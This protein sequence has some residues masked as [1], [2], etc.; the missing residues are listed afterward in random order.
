MIGWIIGDKEQHADLLITEHLL[1]KTTQHPAFIQ[2]IS[3]A[4]CYLMVFPL[5]VDSMPSIVKSFMELMSENSQNFQGKPIYFI[6]HSGFPE[7]VQNELLKKYT[8]YFSSNIMKMNYKGTL[9]MAGSEAMQMA[10]D[11]YFNKKVTLF[12][13]LL[14]SIVKGANFDEAL[15]MKLS[16]CYQ[17]SP[18]QQF[19][20]RIN[21]FKDFYWHYRLKKSGARHLVKAKPYL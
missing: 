6:I 15:S 9:I 17:L 8:A 18:L 13:S 11:G 1:F 4:D 2:T 10:P 5:Y 16:G 19:L 20:Y 12:Q 14:S 7:I 3:D 21:P